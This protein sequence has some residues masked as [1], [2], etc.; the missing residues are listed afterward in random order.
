MVLIKG[1]SRSLDYSSYQVAK[2][3]FNQNPARAALHLVA[4]FSEVL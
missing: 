2:E 1:G 4:N 3:P